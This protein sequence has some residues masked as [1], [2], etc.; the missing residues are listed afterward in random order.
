MADFVTKQGS[1]PTW[2]VGLVDAN[3]NK[4]NLTG[5]SVNFVMRA[6]SASSP[7]INSPA[8]IVDTNSA[9]VSY[10]FTAAQ[11]AAAGIYAAEFQVTQS[12]G[13]LV[14]SPTDGYFEISIEE[15]LSTAGGATLVSLG[16]VKE[17]LGISTQDKSRDAK[18]VRFINDVTPV[19]EQITGPILERQIEE[20]Y[21]GGQHFIQLRNR[22]V[23]NLL[24]CSE[25]RGPIEYVLPIVQSP[26]RGQIY[27]VELDGS[28]IVRRSAGGGIIAFPSLPQSVHVVYTAGYTTVPV[29]VQHAT[30]ELIRI[31]FQS[32]QQGRPKPGGGGAD[33]GE[34]GRQIFGFFVPNSVR[35][36]LVPNKRHASI[37]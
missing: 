18:L 32:T 29:N 25:Y 16:E 30:L 4:L 36:L 34:P 35:E 23:I 15:N 19:I 12:N 1:T 27:S 7:V 22:P 28:R 31:Q 20:W 26:D 11:T 6:L 10:T 13:V 9:N 17:Y 21:D 24:A 33:F 5:A 2:Q 3:G 37:V 14:T 8:T